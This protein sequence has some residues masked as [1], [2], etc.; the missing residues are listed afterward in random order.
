[1]CIGLAEGLFR[2]KGNQ[3]SIVPPNRETI[4]SLLLAWY[5]RKPSLCCWMSTQFFLQN[6]KPPKA[7]E[8]ICW[9]PMKAT[10]G[11]WKWWM[12]FVMC[13]CGPSIRIIHRRKH[14]LML[15]EPPTTKF[16][17]GTPRSGSRKCF[18]LE[19]WHSTADSNDVNNRKAFPRAYT[20]LLQIWTTWL[21][22]QQKW[23]IV[24]KFYIFKA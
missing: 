7:S 16:I 2:I 11:V 21:T 18:F 13:Y 3:K 4:N 5:A 20:P 14:T 1:M 24:C 17:R 9:K 12:I 6:Y 10:W 23:R 19:S 8:K 22:I 15:A